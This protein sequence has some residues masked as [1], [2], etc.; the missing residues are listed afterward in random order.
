MGGK[1]QTTTGNA[2]LLRVRSLELKRVIP[3]VTA[4]SFPVLLFLFPFVLVLKKL[5]RLLG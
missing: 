3:R 2:K 1:A 4:S 5:D